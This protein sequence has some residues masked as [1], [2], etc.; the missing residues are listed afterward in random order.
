MKRRPFLHLVKGRIGLDAQPLEDSQHQPIGSTPVDAFG[1][2]VSL[3]QQSFGFGGRR[4]GA[5]LRV[6]AGGRQYGDLQTDRYDTGEAL[7]AAEARWCWSR[8]W[9]ALVL[10]VALLAF[11]WHLLG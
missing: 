2:G 10:N 11:A 8:L 1:D 4:H 7:T 9:L 3:E 5:S 6:V